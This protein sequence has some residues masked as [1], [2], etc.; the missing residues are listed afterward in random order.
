MKGKLQYI[1]PVLL[2]ICGLYSMPLRIFE[3]DLSKMPGD[4]GDTRF[5][6][7]ILEHGHKYVTGQIDSFWDAPF[8]YPYKNV[9]A[10]SDNLLGT[11]P[12]YSAFRFGTDR[13]SAFLFWL[14]SLFIL[15]FICCFI[16]LKKWSGEIILSSVGAYIFAFSIYNLGQF[17]HVQVLPKF[18]A[19]LV[20]YWCWK[21]LS[22][23]KAKNF[24][25]T[26]LGLTYQFY[27]GIYLAFLLIYVLMFL[28][29]SYFIVYKDFKIFSAFK[30]RKYSVTIAI[31]LIVSFVLLF[32]LIQPY[33]E[34]AKS[35]GMRKFEAAVTTIPHPRSYFFATPSSW[36]W[37]VLS[38]HAEGKITDWWNHYL[39]IGSIPWIGI[40]AAVIY[41]LFKKND[42][43][44]KRQLLFVATT[45]FLCIAFCLN[46]HGFTLY[47]I[48]FKIPGFSSMRSIDRIINLQVLV[49]ILVF[50]FAFKNIIH[51]FPKMKILLYLLPV[52]VV[53]ENQVDPMRVK[54]FE[55]S[56]AQLRIANVKANI[57]KHYD[58]RYSAIAYMAFQTYTGPDENGYMGNVSR[59]LDVMLACQELK[60]K[61]VN[62]YTG[63]DPGN[64]LNFFYEP[65]DK[66][67]K[68][69]CE[70]NQTDYSLI[71]H[72]NDLGRREISRTKINLKAYNGKYVAA[73]EGDNPVLEANRDVAARWEQYMMVRF[74]NGDCMI[75]AQT[76][77][78]LHPYSDSADEIKANEKTGTAQEI[79]R[80]SEF[81]DSTVA[82]QASN[83]KYLSVDSLTSRIVARS[84]GIGASEKF[85]IIVL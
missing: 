5:N 20:V 62:S 28:S 79:F 59:A 82:I 8:L 69:W 54:R 21:F 30:E 63:F 19:P 61:C 18:I 34:V 7:Y 26:S 70:F 76:N 16:A 13:E 12:I 48:I 33:L 43:T 38:K 74:D 66:T 4:L 49:F 42:S 1:I 23:G 9:T 53:L 84:S 44:G 2:L 65:Y 47:G 57:E 29:I 22:E 15:N 36:F 56:S 75:K 77:L 58:P 78:L 52:F 55:K 50:V 39:F 80:L 60:I 46:V 81:A 72:I 24:V 37:N 85:R 35:M 67:L 41:I 31:S 25:F 11:L 14:I 6:N 51:A 45:L 10:L 83:G 64:Y 71:Q 27:C 32:P 40:I 3:T 73:I 68:E 17:D